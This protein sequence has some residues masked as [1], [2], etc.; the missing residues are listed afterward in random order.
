MTVNT[1]G[2]WWVGDQPEDI[3]NFLRAYASEGYAVTEFRLSKCQCGSLEFALEADDEEGVA[4]RTCASCSR[5]HFIGDSGE[6]WDGA[7]AET[8]TC[9]ECQSQCAN[10]GVGFSIYDDDP[11]GV[12]WL[13]VGERCVGC[14]VLGCFAGWKVARS[15]ALYLLDQA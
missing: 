1:S 6:Y 13:Y 3:G 4:R 10:I 12:R 7:V 15:D 2:K 5:Q 11:T 14:G 8:W 9:V